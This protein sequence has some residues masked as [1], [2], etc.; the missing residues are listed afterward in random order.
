MAGG[1]SCGRSTTVNHDRVNLHV[2][3]RVQR[4]PHLWWIYV[5]IGLLVLAVYFLLPVEQKSVVYTVIGV[6]AALAMVV[7]VLIHRPAAPL[8]WL[9][10]AAGQISYATGD[11][12][13]FVIEEGT[14]I[15]ICYLGMYAFLIL[16]LLVFVRRRIP[17]GDSATLIDPAVLAIAA[18]VVWWVYII[19][20]L[21]ANSETTVLI[22]AYPIFD[23]LLLTV[24]LRLILGTGART[25]AFRLLAA[26]LVL[27]LATDVVYAV[28]SANGTYEDGSWLDVGW[29]LSYVSL[30]AAAL[31]PSM[32]WL[33]SRAPAVSR[34]VGPGRLAILVIGALL[35]VLIL[36]APGRAGVDHLPFVVAAA[37]LLMVLVVARLVASVKSERERALVDPLTGLHSAGVFRA[38]LS[39]EGDR[40]LRTNSQLS[41]VMLELDHFRLVVETYGQPAGD[42][43]LCEVAARMH[44][45]CRPGD[46]LARTGKHSFGVLLP[47]ADGYRA[48]HFAELVRGAVSDP[49]IPLES[50]V[51]I[52]VTASLG[53]AALPYDAPAPGRLLQVT[54]HAVESARAGGGNRSHNWR[55]PLYFDAVAAQR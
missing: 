55:G 50:D 47:D 38:N 20:P 53:T 5:A 42:R 16:G 31:H 15:E 8:G 46:L 22:L 25:V 40:A 27:M 34:P 39:L 52:R 19:A 18:G 12:L 23:L 3:Q 13:Y 44:A 36:V 43:V 2:S 35:P 29:I 26:G 7:G 30:G 24:A 9:L 1:L 10:L 33:D 6:S 11:V 17:R 45:F 54:E 32:R 21:A 49:K 14:P 48:G 37:V 4:V 41:L 51:S 28:Q